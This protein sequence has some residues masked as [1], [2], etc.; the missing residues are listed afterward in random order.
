MTT[1]TGDAETIR[2]LRQII[3]AHSGD[4]PAW[5]RLGELLA[6][7]RQVL[8]E[9]YAKS[10]ELFARERGEPHGLTGKFLYELEHGPRWGRKGYPAG[11]MPA[12]A[13]AYGV[14]LESIGAALDGGQLEPAPSAPRLAPV[15][16]PADPAAADPPPAVLGSGVLSPQAIAAAAPHATE[17]LIRLRDLAV[18]GIMRPSGRQLFPD[19]DYEARL[20][21]LNADELPDEDA[22]W[23]VAGLRVRAEPGMA[24]TVL[25]G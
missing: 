22:A 5:N 4:F 17:I 25:S 6:A 21:D 7:R 13:A 2:K 23:L 16:A 18:A 15:H 24:R 10:R 8:S 14:T 11:R 12:V 19:S 20:W 1:T 3:G 9:R